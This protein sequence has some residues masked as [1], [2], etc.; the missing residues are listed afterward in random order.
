[1]VANSPDSSPMVSNSP[2]NRLVVLI[3]GAGVI[4]AVADVIDPEGKSKVIVAA[5]L[6]KEGTGGVKTGLGILP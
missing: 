3:T 5:A 1:M 6:L 4:G 2:R